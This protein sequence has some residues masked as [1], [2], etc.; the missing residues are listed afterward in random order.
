MTSNI[1]RDVDPNDPDAIDYRMSD[2]ELVRVK[3]E[4]V[5]GFKWLQRDHE[6]PA[7][8]ETGQDVRTLSTDYADLE[9][10]YGK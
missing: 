1:I 7:D 8:T 3:G 5:R 10:D 9:G 4:Y 2:G 6:R